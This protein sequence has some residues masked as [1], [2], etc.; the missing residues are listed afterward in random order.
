MSPPP[1]APGPPSAPDAPS[2]VEMAKD[3]LLALA[4]AGGVFLLVMLASR[5][6][7]PVPLTEAPDFTVEDL[8]GGTLSLATLAEDRP[9]VLNFWASWCGPCRAE[10]PD[11][12]RFARDYPEVQV[13]GL[14][15]NS[16]TPAEVAAAAE[17]F[18][19][20]WPVAIADRSLTGAYAVDVLPTTVVIAPGG[21]VHTTHVGQMSYAQLV[22]AL[23]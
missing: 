2:A 11:I 1:T 4:V 20:T 21:G 13:V 9:V 14:A 23:P 8:D 22:A 10:I 16:G 19:I 15:T 18:G 12:A 6:S 7:A 3:W 17:R 5:G